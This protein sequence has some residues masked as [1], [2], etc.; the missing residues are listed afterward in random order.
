VEEVLA[1][2]WLH[3]KALHTKTYKNWHPPMLL[4][5]VMGLLTGKFFLDEYPI[6]SMLLRLLQ[7][8]PPIHAKP[9]CPFTSQKLCLIPASTRKLIQLCTSLRS[10]GVVCLSFHVGADFCLFEASLAV[11]CWILPQ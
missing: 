4:C 5:E 3:N 11:F 1:I 2:L 6:D 7:N 10:G 9:N 8:L